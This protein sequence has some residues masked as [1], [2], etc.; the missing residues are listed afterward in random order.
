VI[1]A[2]GIKE[3]FVAQHAVDFRKGADGLIAECYAMELDPY[4]GDCVVFV[5][6]TRRSVKVIGGNAMGVWVLLRRFEGGALKAMFPFLEDPSFVSATQGELALLLEGATCEVKAKATPWRKT[7]K[8]DNGREPVLL[9]RSHEK[10][11]EKSQQA[12]T[13][14]SQSAAGRVRQGT[15][16]GEGPRVES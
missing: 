1:W 7:P 4:E 3:V 16:V 2:A 14:R 5:H 13:A 10:E 8:S 6:R 15:R 9:R 12:E 11:I